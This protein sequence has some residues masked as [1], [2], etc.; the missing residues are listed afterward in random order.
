MWI[1]DRNV[2]LRRLT[3]KFVTGLACSNMKEI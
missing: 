2:G 1:H 3:P